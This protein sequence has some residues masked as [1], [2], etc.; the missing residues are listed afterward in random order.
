MINAAAKSLEGP[1][2]PLT[3]DGGG[4][5]TDSGSQTIDMASGAVGGGSNVATWLPYSQSV[6]MSAQGA[7]TP[8]GSKNNHKKKE[9]SETTR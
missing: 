1:P 2:P 5:G 8:K 3:S 7:K 6:G 9:K 4:L